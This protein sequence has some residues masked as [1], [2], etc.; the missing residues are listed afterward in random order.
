MPVGIYAD[1]WWSGWG[2]TGC[3]PPAQAACVAV[4]GLVVDERP[5]ATPPRGHKPCTGFPQ[6]GVHT[7]H[8]GARGFLKRFRE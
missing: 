7:R 4:T 2:E 8:R 6:G 3:F 1:E 5:Q